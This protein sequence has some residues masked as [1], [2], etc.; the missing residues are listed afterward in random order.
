MLKDL[1]ENHRWRAEGNKENNVIS[2]REYFLKDKKCQKKSMRNFEAEK[3]KNWNENFTR[4]AHSRVSK[5][6]GK[7]SRLT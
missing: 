4:G 3:Y 2:N 1:K 6:E 5:A 7:T